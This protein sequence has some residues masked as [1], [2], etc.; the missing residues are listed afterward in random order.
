MTGLAR[1][2]L[3][4]ASAVLAASCAVGP[5]FHAPAAPT[6]KSYL[7]NE[8]EAGA[9]ADVAHQAVAYGEPVANHWYR[10]FQSEAL[11]D[12]V[13][14]ALAH[15]PTI[16]AAGASLRA[17]RAE[18]A[19]VAGQLWPSLGASGGPSRTR[20]NGSYFYQPPQFEEGTAN[21]YSLTADL[22][23]NLDIF[24]GTRRAIEAS[25]ADVAYQQAYAADAYATLV[26]AVVETA[27]ALSADRARI[28]ATEALIA[29]ER[30][31]L[32]LIQAQEHAGAVAEDSV[33]SAQAQL[34][35]SERSLPGLRQAEAAAQN[36]LAALLGTTPDAFDA[37]V[38]DLA[39]FT[40]PGQLPVSLPSDLVAQRPDIRMATDRLHKANAEI[41]VAEAARLPSLAL[42]AQYGAQSTTTANLFSGSAA[43]WSV[44]GDL[45]APIFAGGSLA[46]EARAARARRDEAAAS[47]RAT[48]L[49]A[50]AEVASALQAIG[51]DE[52]AASFAAQERETAGAARTLADRRLQAGAG[53]ALSLLIAESQYQSA[54]LGEIDAT[55]QRFIDTARLMRALGGGWQDATAQ[56]AISESGDEHE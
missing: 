8:P 24:G 35:A 53:N 55:A 22:A 31:Q 13:K 30:K 21:R 5:D 25:Q 56:R 16:E 11:S 45:A 3:L 44:A 28:A 6:A 19:V 49:N 27:F 39:A 14:T 12:L 18:E 20:Y 36:Q 51:N 54:V 34:E 2:A 32:S 9:A 47:Y 43:I 41:G 26:D 40:L 48:V 4:A 15:N 42:T 7:R 1:T 10:L 52:S 17:A 23:Y 33:L 50:F 38:P 37:P 46:A 29:S